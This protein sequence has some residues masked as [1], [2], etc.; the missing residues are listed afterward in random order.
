VSNNS[1]KTN[2]S[3]TPISPEQKDPDLPPADP[4]VNIKLQYELLP[5]IV[6]PLGYLKNIP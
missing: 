3:S 2:A 1:E 4:V 6:A 5:E